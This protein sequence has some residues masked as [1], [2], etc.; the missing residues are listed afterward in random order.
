MERVVISA[1]Q[2]GLVVKFCI[3]GRY[4]VSLSGDHWRSWLHA[5]TS[6]HVNLQLAS[7]VMS[8]QCT[9]LLESSLLVSFCLAGCVL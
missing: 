1:V 2:T 4:S 8:R 5:N 9:D 3:I 6:H 7:S